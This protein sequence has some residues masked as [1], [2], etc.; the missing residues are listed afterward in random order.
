M[1]RIINFI[2]AER[3]SLL[4][5]VL[6]GSGAYV[7][8]VVLQ[9]RHILTVKFVVL[10]LFINLFVT[11]L[12]SGLLK[13]F[14]WGAYKDLILPLVSYAGQNLVYWFDKRYMKLLDAGAKK[15]GLNI[16]TD[17]MENNNPN[18]SDDENDKFNR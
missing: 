15:V 9:K 12:S 17:D 14:K 13:V 18:I 8:F 3:A 1:E 11:Y 16:D 5:A 6:I 4:S 2:G 10:V 7:A